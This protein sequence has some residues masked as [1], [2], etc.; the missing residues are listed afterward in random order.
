EDH[1]VQVVDAGE[2]ARP[3]RVAVEIDEARREP[4]VA[5]VEDLVSGRD[6]DLA[7]LAER[8]DLAVLDQHHRAIDHLRSLVGNREDLGRE[9]REAGATLAARIGVLAGRIAAR[10][11]REEERRE[12]HGFSTSSPLTQARRTL[13]PGSSGAP[14][15]RSTSA[16]SPLSSLPTR[17][18][19]AIIAAASAVSARSAPS[20]L[21]PFAIAK[22]ARSGR[23]IAPSS[24]SDWKAT[25]MPAF[26]RSAYGVR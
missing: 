6:L 1:V 15:S 3:R 5:E 11:E 4:G 18:S 17:P 24:A 14:S 25:R 8:L 13:V 21:I 16:S 2:Q 20:G 22:A 12:D 19:I 9:E 7:A 26:W 10:R 23:S